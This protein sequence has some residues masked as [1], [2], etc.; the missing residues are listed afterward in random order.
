MGGNGTSSSYTAESFHVSVEFNWICIGP[1]RRVSER[2]WK[3]FAGSEMGEIR[4][5][6]QELITAPIR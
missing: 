2:K 6:P 3:M 5:R 4:L 1:Q